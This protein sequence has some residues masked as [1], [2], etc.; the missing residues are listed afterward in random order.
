MTRYDNPLELPVSQLMTR[1]PKT[2][3]AN[4]LAATAL[5]RMQDARITSLF[6]LSP[7]NRTIGIIHLHDLLRAG[8]V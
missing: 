2:I 7:D 1:G 8:V 3:T 4:E 6:I 5:K